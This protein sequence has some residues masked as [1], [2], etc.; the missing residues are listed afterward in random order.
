MSNIFNNSSKLAKA[1]A[2]NAAVETFFASGGKPKVSRASGGPINKYT[3]RQAP[4]LTQSAI[5]AKQKLTWLEAME[6]LRAMGKLPPNVEA[7]IK[8]KL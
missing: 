6:Q 8:A 2:T 4:V 3:E 7:L 1:A 5:A